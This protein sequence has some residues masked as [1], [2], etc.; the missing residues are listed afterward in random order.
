MSNNPSWSKPCQN[1]EA[2]VERWPGQSDVSC[3]RCNASYNASGQRLRDD[4][5]GNASWQDEGIDDLE[6]FEM[7]QLANER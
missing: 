6:G 3:G 5:R 7:Q 4:W 2:T 1:C